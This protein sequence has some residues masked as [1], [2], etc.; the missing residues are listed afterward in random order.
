[1]NMEWTKKG[2]IFKPPG[3]YHWMKNYAQ[4]PAPYEM[5]DR[6]RVFYTS[7]PLPTNDQQVSYTS[8]IDV[9]K[10]NP[11]EIIYIHDKPILELGG[12]GDF[13]EHGIH[14]IM[15]IPVKDEL[16]FYYQGWDIEHRLVC[17]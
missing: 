11:S 4:G 15:M 6:L 8:Y 13:D 10:D 1:M 7:R 2:I 5:E 17:Q 3:Q 16:F 14:P 12:I 9:N